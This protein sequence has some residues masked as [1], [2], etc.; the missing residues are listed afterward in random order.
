MVVSV[1]HQRAK[2]RERQARRRARLSDE[3]RRAEWRAYQAAHRA[4]RKLSPT[5]QIEDTMS[6][7]HAHLPP[8]PPLPDDE[9]GLLLADLDNEES[10]A[11]P[12]ADAQVSE[13]DEHDL[14][15]GL[16][17]IVADA[18]AEQRAVRLDTFDAKAEKER[19][20]SEVNVFMDMLG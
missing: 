19:V 8:P 18:L 17:S 10:P 12:E 6:L 15:A 1:E 4:R 14:I 11:E 13:P 16:E 3:Q 9:I 20:Q 2:A 5:E 7:T